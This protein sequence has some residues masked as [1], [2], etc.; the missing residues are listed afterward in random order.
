MSADSAGV[1]K[2]GDGD[3]ASLLELVRE[4]PNLT[5]AE[6]ETS[7]HFAK[8]EDLATVYTSEA[9]IARRLIAHPSGTIEGLTV[10][11]GGVRADVS[12]DEVDGREIVG[13]RCRVPVAVLKVQVSGRSTDQHA[14]VVS[15]RVFS[16]G[17]E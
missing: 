12:P 17:D 11:D 13:V 4:D 3:A 7:I 6:K 1:G 9:G 10:L 8:D 15:D 5:P 14:P 2:L 16:G